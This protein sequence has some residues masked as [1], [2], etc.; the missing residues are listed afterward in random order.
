[1]DQITYGLIAY[2][3]E[4]MYWSVFGSEK[5]WTRSNILIRKRMD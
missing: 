1:M 5:E 4:Q 3:S 2:E